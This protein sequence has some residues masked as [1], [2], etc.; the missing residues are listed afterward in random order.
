MTTEPTTVGTSGAVSLWPVGACGKSL[1][2]ST[3]SP[4]RGIK[5]AHYLTGPSICPE[6]PVTNYLAA[7]CLE[8]SCETEYSLTPA[9]VLKVPYSTGALFATGPRTIP[10]RRS[11]GD[12]E[13]LVLEIAPEFVSA[14]AD[15]LHIHGTVEVEP[16]WGIRDERLRYIMLTLRNELLRWLPV[17]TDVCR[18]YGAILCDGADYQQLLTC[19]RTSH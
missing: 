3:N 19:F 1:L 13:F 2:D 12:A 17:G 16:R 6:S 5:L 10:T 8:G 18:I 11:T 7:I 9:K 15:Q 14:A 4:W